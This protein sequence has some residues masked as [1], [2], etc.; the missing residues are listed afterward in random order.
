MLW[1]IKWSKALTKL[2]EIYA[3]GPNAAL[4]M[5]QT[6][7][8][9][10]HDKPEDQG[11]LQGICKEFRKKGMTYHSLARTRHREF[12]HP[13]PLRAAH[14]PHSQATWLELEEKIPGFFMAVLFSGSP[15]TLWDKILHGGACCEHSKQSLLPKSS[16]S[17][18]AGPGMCPFSQLSGS[19]RCVSGAWRER[20]PGD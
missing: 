6:A 5:A 11:V 12:C 18:Q 14:S 1:E 16:G 2:I 4:T 20:A 19:N 13:C 3:G 8:D 9:A 7:G 17:K 10:P 15:G